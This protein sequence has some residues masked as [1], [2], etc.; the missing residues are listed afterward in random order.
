[1]NGRPRFGIFSSSVDPDQLSLTVESVGKVLIGIMGWYAVGHVAD[2]AAAQTQL[3]AII[4]MVAQAIP[5]AY[6][7]WHTL[8]GLW[9]AA[10]KMFALLYPSAQ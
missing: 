1:M 4:D 6:T 9:G 5:L 3:Q 8:S 2:P 7:L 10:R